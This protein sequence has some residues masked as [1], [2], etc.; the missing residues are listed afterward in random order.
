MI[1]YIEGAA[2]T[3]C[4]A[5]L[6]SAASTH[7]DTGGGVMRAPQ[8]I[9]D[10]F[11]LGMVV[12]NKVPDG[13]KRLSCGVDGDTGTGPGNDLC[14][15][16][17]WGGGQVSRVLGRSEGGNAQGATLGYTT[18]RRPRPRVHAAEFCQHEAES[19]A[20]P[21]QRSGQDIISV[22]RARG[23]MGGRRGSRTRLHPSPPPARTQLQPAA[24]LPRAANPPR[25]PRAPL[26][27][28]GGGCFPGRGAA[29]SPG[30]P[31]LQCAR[32][33]PAS[34]SPAPAPPAPRPAPARELSR[35]RRRAQRRGGG[36]AGRGGA[37]RGWCGRAGA[38]ASPGAGGL[39]APTQAAARGDPGRRLRPL[40]C[41]RR[42]A[43]C[44]PRDRPA[45]PDRRLRRL[46][47]LAASTRGREAVAAAGVAGPGEAAGKSALCSHPA[48]PTPTSP[49]T[50]GL[51][52]PPSLLRNWGLRGW[53]R[54][55]WWPDFRGGSWNSSERRSPFPTPT[56][57]P[58]EFQGGLF[59]QAKSEER[60]LDLNLSLVCWREAGRKGFEMRRFPQTSL[61]SI[62]APAPWQISVGW[63]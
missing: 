34:S 2:W 58:P 18:P 3:V 31:L 24:R 36:G 42:R 33:P 11:A 48:L 55:F 6:P 38:G 28:V 16:T 59:P 37:A 61:I 32:L 51:R 46:R 23:W 56:P 53:C 35:R 27:G 15:A 13:D 40:T 26:E 45:Q 5:P 44:S 4:A 43:A 10:F 14:E 20:E 60:V 19:R 49:C 47:R 25:N 50:P 29:H 63:S 1:V 8:K 9:G 54:A 52:T 17:V 22:G 57:H 62:T 7:V 21:E 39:R 12:G 30:P 41:P